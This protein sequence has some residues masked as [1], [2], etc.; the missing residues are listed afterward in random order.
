M[1]L[2]AIYFLNR[3]RY[4]LN[5]ILI[6][7]FMVPNLELITIPTMPILVLKLVPHGTFQRNL[8]KVSKKIIYMRQVSL[9]FDEKEW[10]ILQKLA[11][12]AGYGSVYSFLMNYIRENIIRKEKY[13]DILQRLEKLEE[14]VDNLEKLYIIIE[15]LKLEIKNLKKRLKK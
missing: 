11:K 3:Y 1:F 5:K 4:N 12:E 6:S 8:Y 13:G 2:S 9:K 14:K 7:K 15:Q 10:E